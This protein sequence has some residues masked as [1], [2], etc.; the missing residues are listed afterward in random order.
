MSEQTP[1]RSG[2][3]KP[4][5]T[6]G[7][8]VARVARPEDYIQ[9]VA[10]RLFGGKRVTFT[11][12]AFAQI[13][14][15]DDRTLAVVQAALTEI[16]RLDERLRLLEGKSPIAPSATEHQDPEMEKRLQEVE[17]A[18]AKL[19]PTLERLN[20]TMDEVAKR[21]GAMEAAQTAMVATVKG[22]QETTAATFN[23][24]NAQLTTQFGNVNTQL[25]NHT[26]DIRATLN[27]AIARV[28]SWWQVPAVI[29]ATVAVLGGLSAFLRAKGWLP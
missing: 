29:V 9:R 5:I 19:E 7:G 21:L 8:V 13:Q 4:Q 10:E 12:E 25:A 24:I 27:T 2:E 11:E 26:Q 18:L 6:V 14:D 20:T 23:G 17:L 15:R 22:I 16:E 1:S 28:P 3:G